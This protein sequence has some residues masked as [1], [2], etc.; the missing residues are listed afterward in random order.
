MDTPA[1][2]K[3]KFA[4]AKVLADSMKAS[5]DGIE[6]PVGVTVTSEEIKLDPLTAA[7]IKAE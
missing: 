3:G 6:A 5:A 4:G 1:S 2:V 7:V